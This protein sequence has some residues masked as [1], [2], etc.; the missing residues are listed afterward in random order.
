MRKINFEFDY[1]P[2]LE[3]DRF[4]LRE[5]K[6]QDCISLFEI[7][8]DEETIK[9]QQMATMQTVEQA[10]K[11]VQAFRQGFKNRKFIRWCI[12]AKENDIVIGLITLHDFNTCNSQAEIGFM[13]NKKYWRQNIMSEV[14]KEIIRFAFEVIRLQRLEASIHPDNIA[15]IKL[16]EKL[17]FNREELK[18]GSAYNMRTAEYEDRLTLGLIRDDMR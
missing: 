13:I 17:G 9:Y 5:V 6:E 10:Q 8:S 1:F 11:S 7:Y 12:A 2:Q 18:K 16:S 14:A 15:S 4:I 3:S